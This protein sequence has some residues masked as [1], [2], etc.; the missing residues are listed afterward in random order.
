MVSCCDKP[1]VALDPSSETAP[2][3]LVAPVTSL[4]G[5]EQELRDVDR[6][7]GA[8][9]VVTLLGAGGIGKTR[10][11]LLAGAEL[12]ER[13]PDGV[14]FVELASVPDPGLV[15][16]AV[17]SALGLHEEAARPPA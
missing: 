8:H 5:R 16:Q 3:A 17:A 6:L 2:G 1:P 10:L 12:R 14:W 4:I 11:S 13:Y 9:R 7:L 15:P